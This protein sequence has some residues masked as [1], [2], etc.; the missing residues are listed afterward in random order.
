MRKSIHKILVAA[1]L[2]AVG[3]STFAQTEREQGWAH[4][5]AAR[6]AAGYHNAVFFDHT[7]A[8]LVVGA[9][10]PFGRIAR[11]ANDRDPA[12]FQMDPVKV[13]DNL[14][15][16]GEKMQWGATPSSWAITTSEGII[17][18]DAL[19]AD[20]MPS[21]IIGGLE[22][23]GL[24]PADIKIILIAHGHAD[25]TG[26]AKYLQETYGAEVYMGGPDWEAM[27]SSPRNSAAMPL[28]GVSVVDGQEVT[29]G[30]TTVKLFLT[31]GHTPGTVSML[32]PVTDNGTPHV[33]ALW[34]GTGM[35]GSAAVYSES[36]ARFRDIVTAAGADVILS[37]HPQIDN[38]DV[39]LPLFKFRQPGDPNPY[40]V[41]AESVQNYLT[42][43]YH[44]AA[45]AT[46]MT[47]EYQRY[48]GR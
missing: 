5:E 38:S 18:I 33:A 13:F 15:Y 41:G 11:P 23:L 36:A 4:I 10:L 7:C 37:T 43:A 25:H 30:D 48:L 20:S 16:L 46:L 19:Y 34:G 9:D 31:P 21:Q 45:A 1:G 26:G 24:D 28:P 35:Q 40:V 14:Y 27:A 42:V 2:C 44:C 47:E 29:L 17:L 12:N 6:Q 39:K 3:A 8:R 32:I 22:K